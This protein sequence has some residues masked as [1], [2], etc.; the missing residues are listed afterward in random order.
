MSD[1]AVS[2][3]ANTPNWRTNFTDIT[4][5]PSTQDSGPLLP[6]NF[7]FQWQMHYITPTYCSN[8]KYL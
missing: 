7:M 4:I 6:E 5:E 8:Q 1:A 2:T 3:I